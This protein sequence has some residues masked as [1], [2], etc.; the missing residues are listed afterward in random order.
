VRHA[1]PPELLHFAGS[2]FTLGAARQSTAVDDAANLADE[3]FEE[4]GERLVRGILIVLGSHDTGPWGLGSDFSSLLLEPC[5]GPGISAKL[6][7]DEYIFCAA[8]VK[9]TV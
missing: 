2:P 3:A 7:I 9:A 8:E 1:L 4:A 6:Y 5:A